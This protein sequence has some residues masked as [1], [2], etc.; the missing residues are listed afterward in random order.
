MVSKHENR[1]L[2]LADMVWTIIYR[3]KG[4][5]VAQVDVFSGPAFLWAEVACWALQLVNKP[6]ILGL[7]GGNLPVFAAQ[8]PGR[9]KRL[10]SSGARVIAPSRFL[11]KEMQPYCQSLEFLPNPIYL[12]AYNY[13]ARNHVRPLLVWL[14]A[15]HHIYNPQMAPLVVAELRKNFSGITLTMIGPDK[16]DGTLRETQ[17]LIEKLRLQGNIEIIPGVTKRQVPQMLGQGDIFIN[18]TNV[19]NT[20]VSVMEA[21]ACGLCIVSTDVGGIPYLL[22]NELDALLVPPNNPE[23]M[24]IAV[25]RIIDEPMLAEH[26]S[27]NARKKAE[28]FD[29]SVILPQWE[30]LFREIIER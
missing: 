27:R 14:R 30:K 4:F 1:L 21:M 9:V 10:L 29:W 15:F 6:Y 7:R 28:Q 26:L 25:R 3:Q 11:Y 24:S 16:G 18:T 22:E 5:Q 12:S 2:R 23:A 8:W 19:D 17:N 20:P 13:Q